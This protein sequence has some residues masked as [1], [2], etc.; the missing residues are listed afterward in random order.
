[1]NKYFTELSP[2]VVLNILVERRSVGHVLKVEPNVVRMEEDPAAN[3]RQVLGRVPRQ[4][5]DK[6]NK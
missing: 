1:M 4:E 6:E 3:T 5:K 2:E